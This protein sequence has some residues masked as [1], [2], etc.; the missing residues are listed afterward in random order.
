MTVAY[1]LPSLSQQGPVIVAHDL[2]VELVRR[3]VECRVF[4]FDEAVGPVLSFPC[5]AERIS[6]GRRI[7]FERFD[8]VHSHGLRPDAYVFVHKPWRRTRTRFVSTIHNFVLKDFAAQYNRLTAWTAGNLWMVLLSRH[9]M[10]VVLSRTAMAYYRRWFG[11]RRL[12]Y[13]YNSRSVDPSATL[14]PEELEELEAFRG[15]AAFIGVNAMLT[16]IK[17]I[18][19]ILRSMPFIDGVRLWV[20]GDGKSLDDLRALASSLG[21]ADRVRFAG[22]RPSAYRYLPYYDLYLMPSRS[23]GF[24]LALLEA[25]AMRRNVVCSDIP[26]LKEIF[27]DEEVT[28]FE[29]E[30]V[31]SLVRAIKTALGCD[32]S[33][34]AYARY[35][36]DYSP[37]R[38]AENYLRVYRGEEPEY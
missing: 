37:E 11:R 20:V 14:T 3:G 13:V 2:I 7:A 38:F 26:V 24:P 6:F 33:A 4:Y 17:G 23:E 36:R 9:D 29:L 21:V 35:V 12:T 32:K 31:P 34:R 25:V 30:N 18:D 19:L 28:F 22:R 27:T 8:V 16:P 5:E 10:R 15:V 1:L